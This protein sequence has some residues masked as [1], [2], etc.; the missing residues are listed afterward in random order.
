MDV[1]AD[2]LQCILQSGSRDD[3]RAVLVVVHDG[4]VERALQTILNVEAFGS[5]DVL[6]VDAAESGGYA[7]DGF[8]ELFGVFLVDLD[9]EHVNAT[10]YLKQ[11]AL[12]FHDGFAAHGTYIAQT[13]NGSTI[14]DDGYQITLVG[15]AVGILR[16]LL[17]LQTGIGYARRV[18]Q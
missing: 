2:D 9:V 12:A 11:Q 7:L 15:I 14:A 4:N 13:Q 16:I 8:A 1:L 18:G 3:G 17:N 5:L 10:V 6:K